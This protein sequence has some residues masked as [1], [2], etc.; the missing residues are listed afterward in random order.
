MFSDF[1]TWL[2]VGTKDG[3]K[4]YGNGSDT[5]PDN[6][7][8]F[9]FEFFPE[10]PVYDFSVLGSSNP[11]GSIKT[12]ASTAPDSGFY[13]WEGSGPVGGG[14]N[15]ITFKPVEKLTGETN[16]TLVAAGPITL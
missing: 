5:N 14:T 12:I 13:I 16:Y 3:I 1:D 2:E 11:A 6:S 10:I 4:I 7:N 8:Q 15:K 9:G